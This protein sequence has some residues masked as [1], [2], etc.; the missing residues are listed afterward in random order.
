MDLN[1]EEWTD[2]SHLPGYQVSTYGQVRD[3]SG[4]IMAQRK[5]VNGGW[6]IDLAGRTFM[7]N[8]LVLTGFTG[9]GFLLGYR[10]VNANGDKSDNRLSNLVWH[11]R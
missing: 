6:R 1:A 4:N 7:V 9:F 10:P 11:K 2:L 5:S 3:P 8:R